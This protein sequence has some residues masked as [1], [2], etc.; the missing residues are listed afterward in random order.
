MLGNMLMYMCFS[1]SLSHIYIYIY[2]VCVYLEIRHLKYYA[3]FKE[4]D[5]DDT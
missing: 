5:H 1:F 4:I 3:K 2:F